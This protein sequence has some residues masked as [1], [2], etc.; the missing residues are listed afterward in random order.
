MNL[1]FMKKCFKRKRKKNHFKHVLLEIKQLRYIISEN[2]LMFSG[3]S[4]S[5][6]K[7]S[8]IRLL[9][10]QENISKILTQCVSQTMLGSKRHTQIS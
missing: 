7:K 2:A 8:W 6:L 1:E 10:K 3:C 9:S 4:M 5:S